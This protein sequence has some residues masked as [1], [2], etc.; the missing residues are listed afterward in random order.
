MAQAKAAASGP[1]SSRPALNRPRLKATLE[2]P[3][4]FIC[5]GQRYGCWTRFGKNQC[6]APHPDARGEGFRRRPPERADPPGES[7][8]PGEWR[9]RAPARRRS[10]SEGPTSLG[11]RELPGPNGKPVDPSLPSEDRV[12]PGYPSLT[13]AGVT[14]NE[15][16]NYPKGLRTLLDSEMLSAPHVR[17]AWTLLG[18]RQAPTALGLDSPGPPPGP[19]VCM[20]WTPLGQTHFEPSADSARTVFISQTRMLIS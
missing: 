3:L 15:P 13:V 16:R 5:Q 7:W 4:K 20:A 14:V 11:P 12:G 2:G 17:S 6:R 10:T 9:K 1:R 18:L 8:G 19:R